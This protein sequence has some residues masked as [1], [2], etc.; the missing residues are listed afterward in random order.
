[1][2]F[3]P[4]ALWNFPPRAAIGKI[5]AYF[6]TGTA[7]DGGRRKLAAAGDLSV[8]SP[9]RCKSKRSGK[10]IFKYLGRRL[11]CL[12]AGRLLSGLSSSAAHFRPPSDLRVLAPLGPA[13]AA[14]RSN[15]YVDRFPKATSSG[16]TFW[17][18]TGCRLF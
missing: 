15:G 7:S 13:V 6:Q 10:G 17:L 1:M 14:L 18:R 11:R 16:N 12:E 3:A 5:F 2:A 4:P 9:P 8:R